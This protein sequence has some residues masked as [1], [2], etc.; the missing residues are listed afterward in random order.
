MKTVKTLII[1]LLVI[2]VT[3]LT[4]QT[5]DEIID[6]YFENTGGKDAWN[7]IE[8]MKMTGDASMGPQSF[9]FTQ[10]LMTDGKMLTEIEFQGQKLTP[11]AFDGE[12]LWGLN[13]QTMQPEAQDAE[14]SANYKKNEA[15]DF[16]DP[17]LNYE[18]KGYQ[19]ELMGE[20]T[21]EGTETYKIKLT[22]NK[23]MSD[24]VEEENISYYYFDKE[25]F[26]PIVS[27]M[28]MPVGPQK[29]MNVQ[30]KYSDYQE[31][32]DI[33]FPYALETSYNG[34]TGQSIKMDNIEIN[35]SVEGIDFSMP[36]K[37]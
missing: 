23:V 26:V 33:F 6:N 12:Q 17:F 25:N 20:E 1:A 4:A 7:K 31:A 32:G 34:Q 24:G 15:N 9:P 2:A 14:A 5:A 19:V 27:E 8:A 16:P 36:E 28:V 3:P 10:Y 13:F 21:K 30:T 22:K 35:P 37:K 11:Q 18:E 29:G